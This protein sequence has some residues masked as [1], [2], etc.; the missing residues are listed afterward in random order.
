[1]AEKKR[2][3]IASNFGFH[4]EDKTKRIFVWQR[5]LR[6]AYAKCLSNNLIIYTFEPVS[7]ETAALTFSFFP[8]CFAFG[9]CL[10]LAEVLQEPPRGM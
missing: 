4:S 2:N 6:M 1:M 5:G 8:V 9:R 7:C 10:L 3:R